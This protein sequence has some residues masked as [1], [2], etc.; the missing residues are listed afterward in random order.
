M[1]VAASSLRIESTYP[2]TFTAIGSPKGAICVMVTCVPGRQPI[3]NNFKESPSSI[4]LTIIPLSPIFKS[5]M[6]FKLVIGYQLSG[7]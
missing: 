2:E 5:A 4:K 7:Y 6:V 3:S 1:I